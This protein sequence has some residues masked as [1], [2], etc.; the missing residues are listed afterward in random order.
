MTLDVRHNRAL[1]T[2]ENEQFRRVANQLTEIF[3]EYNWSGILIG[4]PYNESFSRFRADAIL[5]Y[6]YGLIIIVFKDYRGTIKLPPNSD[7]FFNTK[8][9]NESKKDKV[10][11]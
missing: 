4:N 6:N 1:N 9:F 7:E 8:W 10:K 11:V 3:Q 5:F 2:H